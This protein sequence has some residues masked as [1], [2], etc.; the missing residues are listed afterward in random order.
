MRGTSTNA[1]VVT[2]FQQSSW[3]YGGCTHLV[4]EFMLPKKLL[5]NRVDGSKIIHILHE[6]LLVVSNVSRTMYIQIPES[7]P[8]S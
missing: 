4:R 7:V 1:L 6:D 5:I 3:L 8:L 2:M